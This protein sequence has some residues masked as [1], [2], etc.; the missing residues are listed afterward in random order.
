MGQV[1]FLCHLSLLLMMMMMMLLLS[2]VVSVVVDCS[3]GGDI[4]SIN[5][6]FVV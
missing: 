5:H 6:H 4:Y 2:L 1:C 3:V